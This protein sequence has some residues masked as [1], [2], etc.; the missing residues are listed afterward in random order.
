MKTATQAEH[1]AVPSPGNINWVLLQDFAST[2]LDDM[3][4]LGKDIVAKFYGKVVKYSYWNGCSTG[5]RQGLIQAQ[6]FPTNY[7]GIVAIAPAINWDSFLV[8]ELWGQYMMRAEKYYPPACE[9]EVIRKAAIEAC[10]GIDGVKV[11]F[12]HSQAFGFQFK[13]LINASNM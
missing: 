3:T 6:R 8:A 1:W 10:D 9:L 12:K 5:G 13:A 7:N 4:N 11:S 2:A